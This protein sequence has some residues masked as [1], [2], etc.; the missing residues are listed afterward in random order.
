MK[1]KK[2]IMQL[3]VILFFLA[4]IYFI[5]SDHPINLSLVQNNIYELRTFV[6]TNFALSVFIF[7]LVRL[8]AS[9]FAIP[10]NG[11]FTITGGAMFGFWLGT[12]ISFLSITTG[13]LIVFLI[14]RYAFK[15]TV[16]KRFQKQFEKIDPAFKKYGPIILLSL[17]LM[18]VFPSIIINSVFALTP[19]SAIK[20]YLISLVGMLP[21]IVILTN[22]GARISEIQAFSDIM[23][24]SILLSLLLVAAI[25][26]ITVLLSKFT[27]FKPI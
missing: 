4:T 15:E 19:I 6:E 27:K 11:I 17:R 25:P 24:P 5:F 12:T 16:K 10:G 22:A 18:H 13:V 26:I 21:G 3:S 1:K 20:Y 8:L 9:I 2:R 14:S 23:T 7:M